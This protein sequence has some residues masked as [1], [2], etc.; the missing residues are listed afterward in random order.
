MLP[1][2]VSRTERSWGTAELVQAIDTDE[3]AIGSDKRPEVAVDRNG[4]AV[5]VW[6]Q[7]DDITWY[8]WSNRFE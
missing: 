7:I 2:Q 3:N 1:V 4:N 5:A 6:Q 8:I